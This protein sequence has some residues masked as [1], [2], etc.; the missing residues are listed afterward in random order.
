[1]ENFVTNPNPYPHKPEFVDNRGGNTLAAALDAALAHLS[2]TLAQPPDV[3]IATG[4]FNAEGFGRIADRLSGARHVRLM[5]GAEPV[6]PQARP[7]RH[8]GDPRGPRFE[9]KLLREAWERTEKGMLRDRDRLAFAPATD[10]AVRK[11]LDFL[12]SGKMEVRRY[13]QRF[14]HG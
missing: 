1:M 4:Y 13:T 9:A 7:E 14:L 8:L 10:A 6:P 5:L 3:D 12:R 2:A 11:M